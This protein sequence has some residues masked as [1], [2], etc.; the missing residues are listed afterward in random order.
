MNK[1]QFK[2]MLI[3]TIIILFIGAVFIP[4]VNSG[5]IIL[6]NISYKNY[7]ASFD[8][9]DQGWRYRMEIKINHN[10]V[11]G[12]LN[13]F[14]VLIQII[15]S[16]L[17]KRAQEDGDDILFTNKLGVSNKLYHEIELYDS[18]SGR[19][20]AWVNVPSLSS[21]EDT[22]IYMYYGNP[23]C[24]NQEYP[25]RV[26]DESYC[27]VWHLDDLSDISNNGNDGNNH[28]TDIV[29]GKIGNARNFIESQ[30]DYIDWG[31]MPEPADGTINKATFEAWIKPGD[32]YYGC[33]PF[34]KANSGDFEPDRLSYVLDL[35]STGKIAFYACS[36]TWYPDRKQIFFKT[37]EAHIITGSWQHIAVVVDL[38]SQ[39]MDIYYNGE[40]K[41][42]T[43][44]IQGTPPA[45]LYNIVLPDESGRS[46]DEIN[47]KY[48]DGDMDELKISKICR[49]PD[50]IST[51]YNNQNDPSSF[52]KCAR[53]VPK[54]SIVNGNYFTN[55]QNYLYLFPIL[56]LCTKINEIA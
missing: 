16:H 5:N 52:I 10:K 48:Y 25:E 13:N 7:L 54:V 39:N 21:S 20:I 43:K 19:L 53:V 18:S 45:Y 32:A 50:W 24:I 37:V 42:S 1:Y 49:S 40:E 47:D 26:W 36:G 55:F 15:N 38:S 51:E 23:D 41:D 12:D 34:Q 29:S 3:I 14:P 33:W 28:G 11:T 4:S 17:G 56:W 44:T 31:D 46:I 8:P 2:K 22:V 30:K 6:K 35:G 9:F 27:A